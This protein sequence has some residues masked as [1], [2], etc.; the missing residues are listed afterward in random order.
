MGSASPASQPHSYLS[1][2]VFV[3]F[4][5]LFFRHHRKSCG[6]GRS[7]SD[8]YGSRDSITLPSSFCVCF[9]VHLR[10]VFV[11]LLLLI[12]VLLSCFCLYRSFL[13]IR[14]FSLS[15]FLT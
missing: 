9:F 15:Y 5:Y 14:G 8:V 6:F 13:S 11:S 2:F 4:S 7:E 1:L 10:C 3:F 12:V